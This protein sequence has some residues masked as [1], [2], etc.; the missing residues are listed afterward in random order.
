MDEPKL[1][2]R[3]TL[4]SSDQIMMTR[5]IR[6]TTSF[7]HFCYSS[8]PGRISVT[9]QTRDAYLLSLQIRNAFR[10]FF[11]PG[12]HFYCPLDCGCGYL[13][14]SSG[15]QNEEKTPRLDAE[16]SILLPESTK[17]LSADVLG[18][19]M[20]VELKNDWQEKP[21]PKSLI[22]LDSLPRGPP[23]LQ[24]MFHL[25]CEKGKTKVKLVVARYSVAAEGTFEH[26]AQLE[27]CQN[28][29]PQMEKPKL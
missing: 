10:S 9:L 24:T 29:W 19:Q 17:P 12:M 18:N 5:S 28:K 4:R 1:L 14:P 25:E 3:L 26:K 8:D 6:K 23:F 20:L 2:T 22:Y 13:K 11:R 15:S 16:A 21:E 27:G 7:N